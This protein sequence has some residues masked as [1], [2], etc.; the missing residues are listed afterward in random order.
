[1]QIWYAWGEGDATKLMTM[2]H[3][4]SLEKKAVAVQVE[5]LI[6]A[7]VNGFSRFLAHLDANPDHAKIVY[8]RACKKLFSNIPYELI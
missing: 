2:I 5:K 1:M 7:L 8:E 3:R 4:A 6:E